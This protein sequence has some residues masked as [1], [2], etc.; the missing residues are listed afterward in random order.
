MFGE[1]TV[2]GTTLNFNPVGFDS[3]TSGAAADITEG[4]LFFMVESNDKQT[5][6][7]QNLLIQETGDT[8]L[9]GNVPVGSLGTSSSVR[10][11]GVVQIVEVDGVAIPPITLTGMSTPPLPVLAPVYT[12]LPSNTVSDGT[13]QLGVDGNGGP[14]FSTQWNG[15]LFI[16]IHDALVKS[17]VSFT[18][19]A[20]KVTANLN[21]V[22]AATS[23]QGTSA[24]IAKKD[25]FTVTTNIPEPTALSM[26][27]LALA[28]GFLTRRVR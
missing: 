12:V 6:S 10:L 24:T 20:T 19:G 3:A 7:I 2:G 13:W 14:T 5:Q 18:R 23:E 17:G 21:N 9:A 8:T 16:D 15:E 28:A 11:T 26:C 25:F 22:L 1:P 4:Q 27:V